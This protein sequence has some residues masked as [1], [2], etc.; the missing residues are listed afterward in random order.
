MIRDRQISNITDNTY[1]GSTKHSDDRMTST[2]SPN[3]KSLLLNINPSPLGYN[4][5]KSTDS[6]NNDAKSR[7]RA[8]SGRSADLGLQKNKANTASFE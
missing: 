1:L 8:I 4:E 2:P 5:S 7:M 6:T 3:E